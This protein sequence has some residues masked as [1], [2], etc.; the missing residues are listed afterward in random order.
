M[1]SITLGCCHGVKTH[2]YHSF[3]SE[4]ISRVLRALAIGSKVYCSTSAASWSVSLP[5]LPEQRTPQHTGPEPHRERL[6]HG[7]Y[8]I[9][10][11]LPFLVEP[12]A[13]LHP[14]RSPCLLGGISNVCCHRSKLNIEADNIFTQYSS[15]LRPIGSAW[16][17]ELVISYFDDMLDFLE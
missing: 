17:V 11:P 13:S 6:K 5:P 4:W 8:A 15:A 3:N 1:A 9:M 16:L 12:S 14:K 2:T 7:V 10:W